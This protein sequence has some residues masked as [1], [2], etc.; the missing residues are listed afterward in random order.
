MFGAD[1]ELRFTLLKLV[2]RPVARFSVRNVFSFQDFVKAGK[3]VFIEAAEERLASL[4][5]KNKVNASR[6]SAL[7]G[8]YR[9]EVAA[10]YK[11][12]AEPAQ[13]SE[14]IL[15]R[16]L[17]RW[18]QDKTY[19]TKAGKPRVLT[20]GGLDS[21]FAQLV[22]DTSSDLNPGTVLF[23]LERVGCVERSGDRVKL[24]RA[25]QHLPSDVKDAYQLLSE[26]L[27]NLILAVEENTTPAS[28]APNLHINTQY[29]NIAPGS[30]EKVRDWLDVEGRKFH[31]RVRQFL[32]RYDRDINP[33]LREK[34][35]V[36]EGAR[37]AITIF[38]IAENSSRTN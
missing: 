25:V 22:Q 34:G 27:D 11:D 35:S 36:E 23:E 2:L 37:V 16:V 18:E 3:L 5:E 6:I 8:I 38:S 19:T 31:K 28:G 17:G 21:D 1:S 30:L 26:D 10:I 24:I 33:K 32:A 15:W 4:P 14:G 9:K 12:K 7:T 13:R 29:D 20:Y